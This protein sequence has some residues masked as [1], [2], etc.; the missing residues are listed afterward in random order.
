[1]HQERGVH[2]V[3][4]AVGD[5]HGRGAAGLEPPRDFK[6]TGNAF[7]RRHWDGDVK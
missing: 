3:S 2:V 7:I 5:D 1:M 4:G 6:H